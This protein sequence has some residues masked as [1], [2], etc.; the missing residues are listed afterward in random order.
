MAARTPRAAPPG[1]AAPRLTPVRLE[2]LTDV[3]EPDFQRGG[4]YDGAR[5][6]RVAA[7][8]EELLQECRD[9]YAALVD[10]ETGAYFR[11]GRP[12]HG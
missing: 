1:V 2:N 3:A 9:F 8:V 6:S 11:G 4:R 10:F 7:E 5:Y 12:A